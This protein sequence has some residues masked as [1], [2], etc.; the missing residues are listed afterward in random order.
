MNK[1]VIIIGGNSFIGYYTIQAFLQ[2]NYAV[3]VTSRNPKF[4]DY[5][6]KKNLEYFHCDL[7]S[8]EDIIHLPQKSFDAVILLAGLLPANVDQSTKN[9]ALN[10]K[11]IDINVNG[12]IDIL[13]YCKDNGIS[14]LI[15]TTSYADTSNFWNT[16]HII[17]EEDP[18]SFNHSGDHAMYV[19]S[20]DAAKA[21]SLYYN[22]EYGMQNIIFRLPPVYGVGPHTQLYDN[23]KLRKSGIALFI[24]QAQQRKNIIVFGKDCFRNIVSVKDVAKAFVLATESRNACGLYN[25]MSEKSVSL[26]E[27]AVAISEVFSGGHAKVMRDFSKE[28]LSAS[29]YYSIE[30]AHQDFGYQPCF[31]DPKAMMQD[32]KEDLE[33][34]EIRER[35]HL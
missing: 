16:Q 35:F 21:I 26:F 34:P 3:T 7:A 22:Q 14:K 29:Y 8:A 1:N 30:K 18:I 25:V 6:E 32:Y 23:G 11:Y 33:K 2:S 31:S 19:I 17:T 4:K 20:K 28:N 13:N 5:C 27:Q 24:E 15:S 9:L 10:A 12:Q